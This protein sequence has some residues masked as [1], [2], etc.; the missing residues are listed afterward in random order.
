M[1]INNYSHKSGNRVIPKAVS[2]RVESVIKDN[3]KTLRKRC[4]RSL[5]TEILESLKHYGWSDPVRISAK[6]GLTLTAK[7]GSTALCLQTG[8]MARFYADLLKLQA[9]YLD[10]KISSAIYILPMKKAAKKM[11]DNLANYERLTA[12]LKNM[13]SKVITVPMLIIGFDEIQK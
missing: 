13:F 3:N 11:G 12:E 6:R 7:H 10:N 2:K 8:N 1:K 5:R 9:Q 4:A